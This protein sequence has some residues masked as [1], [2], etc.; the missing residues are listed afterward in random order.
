MRFSS[1][2]ER[3]RI[4]GVALGLALMVMGSLGSVAWAQEQRR[5]QVIELDD[6]VIKGDLQTP[7]AFY[8]LQHSNLGYEVMDLRTSFLEEIVRALDEEPF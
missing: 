1:L 3:A 8:I 6:V 5:P 7:T 4:A 2:I